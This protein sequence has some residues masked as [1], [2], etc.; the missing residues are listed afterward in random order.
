MRLRVQ[1]NY[2]EFEGG[3]LALKALKFQNSGFPVSYSPNPEARML[4]LEPWSPKLHL[5][6]K[7][8][9]LRLLG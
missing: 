8:R 6:S 5:V 7:E 9:T 1:H 3:H 4:I 2:L